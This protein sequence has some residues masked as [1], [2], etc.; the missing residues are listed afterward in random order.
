MLPGPSRQLPGPLQRLA[1]GRPP[2]HVPVGVGGGLPR[3]GGVRPGARRLELL[4]GAEGQPEL[5]LGREPGGLRCQGGT[6]ELG[7]HDGVAVAQ[8]P[9]IGQRLV[10]DLQAAAELGGQEQ[11]PGAGYS[12]PSALP[13]NGQKAKSAE[14]SRPHEGQVTT[15]RV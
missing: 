9:R 11:H 6:L 4:G 15:H 5:L 3:R 12:A 8:R 10:H 2:G 14:L 13:Q 1:H 7:E